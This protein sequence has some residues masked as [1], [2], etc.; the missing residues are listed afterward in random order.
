ML[1]FYSNVYYLGNDDDKGEGSDRDITVRIQMAREAFS[2]LVNYLEVKKIKS[3]VKFWT[4][5][6]NI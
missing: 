1:S 3:S 2:A 5:D 6:S 4:F